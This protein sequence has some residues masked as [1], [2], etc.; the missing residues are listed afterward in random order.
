MKEMR[1]FH[2]RNVVKPLKLEDVTP[3]IKEKSLGYLMLLKKKK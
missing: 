2:D 1:Q 3:D